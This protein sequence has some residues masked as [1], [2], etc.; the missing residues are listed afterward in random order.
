MNSLTRKPMMQLSLIGFSLLSFLTP[1]VAQTLG[2]GDIDGD[3]EIDYSPDHVLV[4]LSDEANPSEA[5]SKFL[6]KDQRL[7]ELGKQAFP[8]AFGRVIKNLSE[9]P[10]AGMIRQL[11]PHRKPAKEKN[12]KAKFKHIYKVS[13]EGNGKSL[14]QFIQELEEQ[15]DIESVEPDYAF[16]IEANDPYL[17][18][19]GA[20]GQTYSDQWYA[21]KINAPQAWA[22]LSPN[23][24]SSTIIAVID[25]GI[26]RL[27]PDLSGVVWNNTDEIAGNGI[28]DDGNGYIDDTHGWNFAKSN[29][30]TSDTHGHGTFIAGLIGAKQNNSFGIAG[31]LP[32]ACI[33]ALRNTETGASYASH[34]IQALFYA[35]NNGAKVVNMSFGGAQHSHAFAQAVRYALDNDVVLVASSGNSGLDLHSHYPSGYDG[36][37]SVGATDDQDLRA[38][39]S[40]YGTAVDIVAPGGGGTD[41]SGRTILSSRASGT[42][43]G[44]SVDT[45]HVRSSGT[46]YSSP[47]VAAASALLLDANPN[48][49]PY[50]VKQILLNSADDL[51]EPGWD[52]QS[53]YGRLNLESALEYLSPGR[54]YA[55]ITSPVDDQY[56]YYENVPVT[57]SAYGDSV[58]GY[59]L[60][61]GVGKDPDSW[62]LIQAS[63]NEVTDGVLG[64]FNATSL[65]SGYYTIR[66]RL[67][68]NTVTL[69]EERLQIIV[70]AVSPP[71]KAGWNRPSLVNV[72]GSIIVHDLDG[73]GTKESLVSTGYGIYAY[74]ANGS[75]FGPGIYTGSYVWTV[76]PVSVGDIDNDGELEIGQISK[77]GTSSAYPEFQK[78]QFWNLDGTVCTGWPIGLYRDNNT[79]TGTLAPTVIDVDGDGAAEVAYP[80][81]DPSDNM[82]RLNLV[83][84]TGVPLSGWPVKL[85]GS[86]GAMSHCTAAAADL[87]G[88]G[89]LD[90]VISDSSGRI[91]A[92]NLQGQYL[93]GWPVYAGTGNLFHEIVVTDLDRNGQMDVIACF[94]N[95]R[96]TVLSHTGVT[97]AGWPQLLGSNPRP[98]A[99]ADMDGDGDLEIAIGTATGSVW[100]KHHDG[101]NLTGWP[102]S[103]TNRAYTPC[104]V[105]LDNDNRLDVVTSDGDLML[106]AWDAEGNSLA[107]FGFPFRLPDTFGCYTMPT[108][109][110]LEGDG[111]LD[112]VVYGDNLEVR[113]LTARNNTRTIPYTHLHCDPA[114]TCRYVL[115][116]KV[117]RGQ[118]F[119]AQV[120]GGEILSLDGLGLLSG[121]T[122]QI[123]FQTATVSSVESNTMQIEVP[124]GL[125][126]GWHDIWITHPNSEP[127][128]LANAV[129][130]VEDIFGDSDDDGLSDFWEVA[131]GFEPLI[132]DGPDTKFGING[133]VDADGVSNLIEEAFEKMNMN[134]HVAD[135]GL[136]PM[137]VIN[138]G[139]VAVDFLLNPSSRLVVELQWSP[140]L[141]NWYSPGDPEYPAGIVTTDGELTPEGA[142]PR[143][144]G[145]PVPEVTTGYFRFAV[146][147]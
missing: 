50:E 59:Q 117:K 29:N 83:S 145:G 104:L 141:L 38:S 108:I 41:F 80:D 10:D 85:T 25:T 126:L 21:H 24:G 54:F 47:L 5:T 122:V 17:S 70:G 72:G 42:T 8:G 111:L 14:K 30:N 61:Y 52:I 136:L 57:G 99:I 51:Y 65:T 146:E 58:T 27:H 84:G 123:G 31:V 121:S 82:V 73:D 103:V 9:R 55:A 91:H 64:I 139:Q 133:D 46:S 97:K 33:M 74:N 94:G 107:E 129:L 32:D 56:I 140:N 13:F 127:T 53:S 48:L 67:L 118:K 95:G 113:Q 135:I 22:S 26:D 128:W 37:I 102:K 1:L 132:Y 112:L 109:E 28:D 115:P 106:N 40:N 92:F 63:S 7:N 23:A 49:K 119:I 114:N 15:P 75:S 77:S 96:V 44:S 86:S 116:G 90:F 89:E 137:P 45:Y 69:A 43:A 66:L 12:G 138:N 88:D 147:P 62:S 20:W 144:I 125:S 110:D 76:G 35:V 134:P 4:I 34:S 130:V 79:G 101:T 11:T 120:S 105:D 18:S 68:N 19:T 93:P 71:T 39:F 2:G 36:I 131:H 100:I 81:V 142:K 143:H 6:Q 3:G 16:H 78:I 124:G 87:D 98:P 60:D